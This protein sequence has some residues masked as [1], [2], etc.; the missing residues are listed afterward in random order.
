MFIRMLRNCLAYFFQ[1]PQDTK[2]VYTLTE[3]LVLLAVH[4]FLHVFLTVYFCFACQICAHV[5]FFR[6]IKTNASRLYIFIS[7]SKSATFCIPVLF[8]QPLQTSLHSCY[9]WKWHFLAKKNI[10]QFRKTFITQPK[11]MV[12][13]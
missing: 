9:G 12:F 5:Q 4:Y 6:K 10:T 7:K 8:I 3:T 2:L 13:C 11:Q 1:N